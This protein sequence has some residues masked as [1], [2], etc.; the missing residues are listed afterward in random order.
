MRN[1]N[2]LFLSNGIY[3]FKVA[4]YKTTVHFVLNLKNDHFEPFFEMNVDKFTFKII[5]Y[6]SKII[7]NMV[8]L[9]T[10]YVNAQAKIS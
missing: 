2:F 1:L 7:F 6:L 8:Y 9:T 5:L 4:N 10:I 3:V